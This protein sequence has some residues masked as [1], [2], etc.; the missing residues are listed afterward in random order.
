MK[1]KAERLIDFVMSDGAD[2]ELSSVS[3]ASCRRHPAAHQP[4]S[5]GLSVVGFLQE[6]VVRCGCIMKAVH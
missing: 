1:V 6:I 4:W 3:G 5:P 2:G